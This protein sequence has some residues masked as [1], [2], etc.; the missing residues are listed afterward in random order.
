MIESPWPLL[1][2]KFPSSEYAL[3]QEVRDK[4]GF[5]AS[6]SA[7][8]IAMNL[9][10]SRGLELEGI[11]VKSYRNDWLS[12]MKKPEKA[13]NIYKF[14]DRWWL[15]AAAENV[16]KLEEVPKTWGLMVVKKNKLVVEK[17]APKL[18]PIP[19]DRQFLAALLKRAT[20]GMIPEKSIDDKV[21]EAMAQGVLQGEKNAVNRR[22]LAKIQLEELQKSIKQFEE[23]SGIK[24]SVW[25]MGNIGKAVKYLSEIG[26]ERIENRLIELK[27]STDDILKNIE[28]GLEAV[29]LEVPLKKVED[30]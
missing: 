18:S 17:E 30:L 16:I 2:K 3:L 23:A 12:E 21:K 7:D 19:V 1:R 20:K 22:E 11:E 24:I 29:S 5:Y 15:I 26:V 14:C 9:W 28:K 8:G 25:G 27:R 13:E 6:R 4:A 10:P